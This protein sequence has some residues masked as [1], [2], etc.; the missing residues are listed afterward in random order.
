MDILF[1]L[2]QKFWQ[3]VAENLT[4]DIHGEVLEWLGY[5]SGHEYDNKATLTFI[6]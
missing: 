2:I 3:C 6:Q 4:V 5:D 1:R